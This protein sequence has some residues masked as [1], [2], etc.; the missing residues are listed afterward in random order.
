MQSCGA[1]SEEDEKEF[2]Q[3]FLQRIL[4]A[5]TQNSF[6]Y[7]AVQYLIFAREQSTCQRT[8]TIK[9]GFLF[10]EFKGPWKLC[11][12]SWFDQTNEKS[13]TWGRI[14]SKGYK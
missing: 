3:K 1:K 12:H 7:N 9:K 13:E 4:A 10:V 8:L 14:F 2:S 5:A 6:Y 11:W